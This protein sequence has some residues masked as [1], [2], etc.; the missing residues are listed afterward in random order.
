M[1]KTR[2]AL[3]TSPFVP[4]TTAARRCETAM[5]RNTVGLLA[6]V[7]FFLVGC[8]KSATSI[9]AS[10][11]TAK[12]EKTLTPQV[13]LKFTATPDMEMTESTPRVSPYIRVMVE[14]V[15]IRFLETN[16]VQVELVIRGTLPD[17]CVYG[18][19]SIETRQDLNVKISLSGIHPADNS[20]IQTNQS[21][22]YVLLLGRDMP[23]SERGFAPGEYALTVNNYQTTFSIK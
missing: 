3:L 19:Y 4:R 2:S 8:V 16:P 21:I 9:V 13:G 11:P 15:E 10:T 12:Q 7:C 6:L 1:Y 18:F 17:Q 23:E 22:E 5:P 14:N 20:C